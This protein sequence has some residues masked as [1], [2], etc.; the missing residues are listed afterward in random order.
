MKE[1]RRLRAFESKGLRR[2]IYGAK[3]GE[4][5]EEQRRLHNEQLNDLFSSPN[6]NLGNKI[7]DN[8]IREACGTY[9][10]QK[11]CIQ[12]LDGEI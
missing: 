2:I 10:R 1:E 3:W 6:I 4:V 8:E 11:R 9:G 12:D 5:K 7:K